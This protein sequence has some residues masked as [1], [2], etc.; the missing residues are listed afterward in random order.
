[1]NIK[2]AGKGSRTLDG[3]SLVTLDKNVACSAKRLNHFQGFGWCLGCKSFDDVVFVD[4]NTSLLPISFEMA[5]SIDVIQTYGFNDGLFRFLKDRFGGILG[6]RDDD[7]LVR[8]CGKG[9]S[10]EQRQQKGC[11]EDL[12]GDF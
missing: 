5:V 6:V 12:H 11:D 10:G 4:N 1:M 9:E 2:S 7:L 3:N 8:R